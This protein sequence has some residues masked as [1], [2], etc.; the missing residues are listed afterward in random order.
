MRG[1]FRRRRLGTIIF[2]Y[3]WNSLPGRNRI[4]ISTYSS[5]PVIA[6]SRSLKLHAKTHSR[7]Y[8]DL[9]ITT[10]ED[11]ISPT[12]VKDLLQQYMNLIN[13]RLINFEVE[14]ENE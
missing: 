6:K 10:N 13:G 1:Q 12:E 9:V 8:W 5:K 7:R 14:L 2:E 11:N 3:E 4:T